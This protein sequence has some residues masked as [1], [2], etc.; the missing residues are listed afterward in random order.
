VCA[1]I[2]NEDKACDKRGSFY[3]TLESTFDRSLTFKNNVERK[4]CIFSNRGVL[5]REYIKLVKI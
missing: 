5:K 4:Y 3:K 1:D 2:P